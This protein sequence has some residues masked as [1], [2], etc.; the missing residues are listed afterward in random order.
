MNATHKLAH[1]AINEVHIS[2][3]YYIAK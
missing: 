2:F 1:F 3:V